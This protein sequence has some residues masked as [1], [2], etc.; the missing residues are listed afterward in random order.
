MRCFF[1]SHFFQTSPDF[2]EILKF[3]FKPLLVKVEGL[4]RPRWYNYICLK[5]QKTDSYEAT[6]GTRK[7]K[8]RSSLLKQ[9]VSA[10]SVL[11]LFCFMTTLKVLNIS[12]KNM[13]LYAKPS[14]FRTWRREWG[15]RNKE[16]IH[17]HEACP[18]FKD[19]KQYKELEI[20]NVYNFL[21]R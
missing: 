21:M 13:I 9:Q 20:I 12:M 2:V 3:N 7:I 17:V 1:G 8:Q 11:N 5:R 14:K 4:K 18:T 19:L 16:Q 10:Y 15:G 6:T